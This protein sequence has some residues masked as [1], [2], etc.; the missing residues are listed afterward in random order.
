MLLELDG[1]PAEAAAALRRLASA[2]DI[3]LTDVVPGAATVLVSARDAGQ[4]GRLLSLLATIELNDEHPRSATGPLVEIRVRYDGPDLDAVAAATG[5][6]VAEVIRRHCGVTYQAAFT[7]FAPGFAYLAGLD[8]LLR[9]PRRS[10]PRPSVP[11][12][13]VAIADTYTAVYPRSS[14][15]GWH[16]LATTDAVLFDPAREPPALLA[17]GTRVR[18]VT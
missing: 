3:A 5:L 6:Y 9:L 17:P 10:S 18:F 4:L 7:G 11:A 14:P 1:S 2:A 13:A 16:L 12:G 15:G 8:P